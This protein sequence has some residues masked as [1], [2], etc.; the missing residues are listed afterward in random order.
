M[1]IKFFKEYIATTL[2]DDAE[3][4]S[5]CLT[6]ILS[7]VSLN[8]HLSEYS[9]PIIIKL[10]S[11]MISLIFTGIAVV[12]THFLKQYLDNKYPKKDK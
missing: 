1:P 2:H 7:F 11:G 5:G 9:S 10:L 3:Y 8:I 12:L 4:I 6:W